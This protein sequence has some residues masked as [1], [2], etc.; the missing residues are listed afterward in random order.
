MYRRIRAGTD[1]TTVLVGGQR[2]AQGRLST[3]SGG[4]YG[5][6]KSARASDYDDPPGMTH[7]SGGEHART[8]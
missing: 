8:G 1:M 6:E 3:A 4:P 2:S 5:I 7:A